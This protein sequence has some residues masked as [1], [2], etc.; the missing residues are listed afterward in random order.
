MAKAT[1]GSVTLELTSR[2]AKALHVLLGATA[3]KGQFAEEIGEMFEA[4]NTAGVES[5]GFVVK[6][7]EDGG[8]HIETED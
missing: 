1:S 5:M 8:I 3:H 7:D 6:R 4:L 2:E